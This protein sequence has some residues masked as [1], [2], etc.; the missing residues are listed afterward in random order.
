[1]GGVSAELP[2]HRRGNRRRRM[3]KRLECSSRRA[4]AARPPPRP[5]PAAPSRRADRWP[6]LEP[7]FWPWAVGALERGVSSCLSRSGPGRVASPEVGRRAGRGQF[8]GFQQRGRP[9]RLG[10]GH[11]CWSRP[12]SWGKETRKP[13]VPYPPFLLLPIQ[14]VCLANF[15]NPMLCPFDRDQSTWRVVVVSGSLSPPPPQHQLTKYQ[16]PSYC[17]Q[18]MWPLL[19]CCWGWG[20]P[21]GL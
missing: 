10:P 11:Q 8:P 18:L 13:R 4:H 12:G 17:S 7:G 6:L 20:Q 9:A 14:L 1:M 16:T 3:Q 15:L 21:P 19:L 5:T 2:F